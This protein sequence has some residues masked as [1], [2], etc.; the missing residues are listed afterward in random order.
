MFIQKDLSHISRK[1]LQKARHFSNDHYQHVGSGSLCEILGELE[2][3]RFLSESLPISED[4]LHITKSK[5][6]ALANEHCSLNVKR[7][8]KGG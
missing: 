2:I 4:R 5:E 7:K 6:G 8:Q 1:W 3:N